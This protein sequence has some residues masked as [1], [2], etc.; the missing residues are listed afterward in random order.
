[1]PKMALH[2]QFG[3]RQPKLWAKEGSGVK[4]TIWF[5]TT[6]SQESTRPQRLQKECDMALKRSQRE[7]QDFFRPHP[8]PRSEQ[9]VMDAQSPGSPNRDSFGIPPWES[10]EK[11]P[12]GCSFSGELQRILYGG[13][14]WLPSSSGRGESSE[15]K[16]PVAC[17]NTKGVL[18]CELT[19]LWLVL[20][21]GPCNK[22]IVPLPS[23][24]PEPQHAP[25]T[26]SSVESWERAPSSKQ[27]R[28]L[29][30]LEPSWV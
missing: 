24:I 12:F 1:M 11:V 29:A 6:K 9:E 2:E 17:P 15:S 22:I 28:C 26:P 4:L 8:N 25:S 5:S 30:F 21:A 3:H 19:N 20:D 16:L 14:W 23:L 7:L 10:R 27:F 18:E 13:R